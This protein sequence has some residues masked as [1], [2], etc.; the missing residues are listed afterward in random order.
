MEHTRWRLTLLLFFL[1]SMVESF[2]MSHVFS[3]MPVYLQELAV[4]HVTVWV[5]VLSALVFVVGLPLVPLWG[6]WAQ[7]FGGKAV[8][9]RSAWVEMVV[10]AVLGFS[11]SLPSVVAAMALVGFQLGNTGIM[12]SSLRRLVPSERVGFAVSTLSVSSPVGMALGPLLGGLVVHVHLVTLHGLYFADGALSLLTGLM[13][14]MLYREQTAPVG[15]HEMSSAATGSVWSAAWQLVK[16]TFSMRITWV[17]FSIYTVL[18]L[19]R[20]MTTPYLPI[21]IERLQPHFGSVTMM[22]GV[23]MGLTALVGAIITVLAGR[24]GD[25]VGFV[26]LLVWAF[27]LSIPLVITLGLTHQ[28]VVFGLTLTA[29]SALLSSGGA[30]IFALLSTRIPDSHRSTALNLVYLPLYAG[31]IIGPSLASALAQFGLWGPFAGAGF[32]F[33]AG[34]IVIWLTLGRKNI[35]NSMGSEQIGAN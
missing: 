4:S 16:F 34:V 12:L 32:I 21:V 31:G 28:L 30:M 27:A 15:S 24:L 22:I 35:S 20:Q 5:G 9:I 14:L 26:K 18:M 6:V 25:K 2:G 23:M 13:L 19:A 7:R 8:I 17:L 1:T 10:F 3:F 33:M 29:Y 11:H